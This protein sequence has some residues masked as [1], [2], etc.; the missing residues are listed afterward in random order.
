MSV[1]WHLLDAKKWTDVLESH[2]VINMQDI[3]AVL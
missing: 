3:V 2:L 1:V